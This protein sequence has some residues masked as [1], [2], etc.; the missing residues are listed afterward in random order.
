MIE[1]KT[2][3]C[4]VKLVMEKIPQYQSASIGI[5]VGAGSARENDRNNGVSHYIEHLFFK[6]TENRTQLQIA[7][8]TDDLGCDM[9]A[10]TG[11]EATCFHIKALTGVFPQAVDILLDMLC[12]SLFAQED[13]ERERGVIL[14]EYSMTCDTP[15]EYI[16]DLLDEKV[17]GSH[18]LARPVLGT[19]ETIES[20]GR[21]D[22]LSYIR[23]WYARDNIVV[24]VVGNFDEERLSM[25][26]EEKLSSFGE[27]S[28]AKDTCSPFGERRFVSLKRE[29][30]QTHLAL[31]LPTITLD[32]PDYY[33]Q[34]VVCDV[35]GGSMSSKLFQ[36]IRE[37]KGLAYSV[38]S[39]TAS[40]ACG[41]LFYIYAGI[42]PGTEKEVLQAIDEELKAL[43]SEGISRAQTEVVKQ[44]LKSGFIFSLESANSRMY[45]QGKNML[46]LGRTYSEEE[47]IEEIDAVT[48]DQVNAFIE[49]ICELPSYS[50]AAIS[51]RTLKL[52]KLLQA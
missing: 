27:H 32:S 44:R 39:A 25:Q 33:V 47:T 3:S 12:N 50:A 4:G 48:A 26:L 2:L 5:W 21:E 22:L 8:D 9:N 28:P 10:F 34:A 15:D 41:G 35:L 18:P 7:R 52:E 37:N 38:Y 14:E 45:R 16:M 6:G 1:V 42:R 20:L 17:F 43:R 51:P 36:N 24:S 30:N 40:F 29:I 19:K 49:R 23:T 31:G 46:L 11:K 13:I